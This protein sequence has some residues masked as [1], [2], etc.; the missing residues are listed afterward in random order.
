MKNIFKYIVGILLVSVFIGCGD[1]FLQ[2]DHYDIIDP[3]V[4]F[5]NEENI[6]KGLNGVYDTFY[7]EWGTTDVGQSWNIKPQLAFSNYPALDC[8]ASGWD[9]EFTRHEW[10]PDKD[11][12][13]EGW[14]KAYKAIDRANRFLLT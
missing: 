7:P 2:I 3:S 1:D 8:Q 12:F 4:M 5:N 6:L 10:R 11:M 14:K 13:Y 9:N